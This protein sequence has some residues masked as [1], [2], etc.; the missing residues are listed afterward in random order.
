MIRARLNPKQCHMEFSG[1]LTA[2]NV[3]V[4]GKM[5]RPDFVDNVPKNVKV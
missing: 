4:Q 1:G 3:G 5:H 2:L